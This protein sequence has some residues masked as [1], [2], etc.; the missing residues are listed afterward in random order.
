MKLAELLD[1][2]W[3]RLQRLGGRPCASRPRTSFLSPRFAPVWLL[4]MAQALHSK[5]WERS[6]KA[7]S[8]LNVLLFSF[9]VPARLSIGPGLVITHPYGTIL[10]AA[11]IGANAT[12]YQQVTLGAT[13]ADFNFDASTRPTVGDGVTITAG[14]KVLGPLMLGDGCTIGANA[15]VLADVPAHALA[16]GIPARVIASTREETESA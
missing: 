3:A 1:A 6:A 13:A 2:D 14:A 16:V 10:G 5:G 7:F 9:E 12:I 8:L 15:V 4:R 11:R